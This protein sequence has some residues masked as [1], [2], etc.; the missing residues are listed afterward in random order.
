LLLL[1]APLSGCRTTA[2]QQELLEAE[3]R[4]RERQ[5]EECKQEVAQRDCDIHALEVELEML[6][7]QCTKPSACPPGVRI[8]VQ[9][10]TLGRLTGGYDEDPD[11]PGDEGL[12]V[13]LEPR[14]CDGQS[15]KAPGAAHIEV[16]EVSKQGLKTFLSSWDIPYRELRKK[17]E[18][19]VF[20]GPAYRITLPWKT[21]PTTETLR[22]RVLFVTPDGQKFEVDRDVEIRLPERPKP[23][24]GSHR[25]PA[26][27]HPGADGPLL[28]PP[29]AECLPPPRPVPPKE[30]EPTPDRPPPPPTEAGT[31][32]PAV[33]RPRSTPPPS[34]SIGLKPPTGARRLPA[35]P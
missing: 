21:W 6:L 7:R 14:D 15:V 1:F 22:V 13:L 26:L 35:P 11:C 16:Y 10:I 18:T 20:G 25:R 8:A 17:W 31:V 5:L 24:P 34:G 12:Q 4:E 2:A 32:A 27:P 30:T 3:L 29:G 23:R 9:N 33:F 19:P 28:C